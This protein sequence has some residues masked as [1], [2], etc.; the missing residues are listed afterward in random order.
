MGAVADSDKFT[1]RMRLSSKLHM[2][3]ARIHD[4]FHTWELTSPQ[5]GKV[6]FSGYWQYA[7]SWT[8]EFTERCSCDTEELR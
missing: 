8:E 6:S 7:A 2:W 4:D 5:G 1:F 3:A